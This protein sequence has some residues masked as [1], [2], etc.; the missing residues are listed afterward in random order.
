MVRLFSVF[1]LAGLMLL[2]VIGNAQE[3]A[4]SVDRSEVAMGETLVLTIRVS[5]Q[6]Q[7]IQLDLSPLTE[8]FDILST[9]T[10]SQIRSI[11]NQVESWVDYIITLFPTQEGDIQIPPLNVGGVI[12]SPLTI[13]VVDAGPKSNQPNNDLFLETEVNKESVFVQEQL[14]FT[15][16]LFYTISGIRNPQFTE[17]E[18]ADTVIQLIG[19]PNQYEKL[20]DGVRYGVYEKRYVIFPQRSGPLEI[21]DVLFRG[22]VTDGSSNFVFRNL[23]TQRVTAYIEGST[24]DIKERP[25]SVQ[26][27]EYWLPASNVTVTESWNID[28]NNLKVGD[29][30][31]RTIELVVDGLDGAVLPPFSPSEIEGANLYPDPPDIQRTFI[32]GKIIGTRIETTSIVPTSSGFI[33]VPEVSIPWWNVDTDELQYA[34]IPETRVAIAT[35]EGEL[36]AEQSVVNVGEEFDLGALAPVLDQSMLGAQDETRLINIPVIW[37]NLLIALAL[38]IVLT[39]IYMLVI[40]GFRI[41]PIALLRAFMH[42]QAQKRYPENN[43]AVAFGALTKA[44]RK[45]QPGA[46]RSAL[47]TWAAHYFAPISVLSM[48]DIIRN[49]SSGSELQ[50][51][52]LQVQSTLYNQAPE[53]RIESGDMIRALTAMRKL[54]LRSTREVKRQQPYVLPPLYRT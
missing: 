6:R 9:R 31:S 24:I 25:A 27:L 41:N 2:P 40:R 16:R 4:V 21:P 14:L 19:S 42:A 20:I 5:Q 36:P 34:V 43:E 30:I 49:S 52:C 50:Q 17:L 12:S 46:I 37:F 45:G 53:Q 11:N 15:I 48:D 33:T 23:N 29:P 18:M 10:S 38:L 47:I 1:L 13:S 3:V 28:I 44:I 54:K 35:I 32:E 51:L 8:N 26:N 7:N 39:S 22:E